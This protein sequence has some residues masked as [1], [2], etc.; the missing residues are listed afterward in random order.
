MPLVK[1]IISALPF[2]KVV[3]VE[4]TKVFDLA[5]WLGRYVARVDLRIEDAIALGASL[6]RELAMFQLTNDQILVLHQV[7]RDDANV[8]F[9]LSSK[10][11]EGITVRD[12][13]R[14]NHDEYYHSIMA[15]YTEK[16]RKAAKRGI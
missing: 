8:L 11:A 3:E 2:R 10:S 6:R 5:N 1:A 14:V 4:K 12:L 9:V 15:A 7:C 16:V 13:I